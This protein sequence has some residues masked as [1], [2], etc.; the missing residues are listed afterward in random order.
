MISAAQCRAAR[1]LIEWSRA[2]LSEASG[3]DVDV[4]RD[5]EY[6][7]RQ[8]GDPVRQQLQEAL[9]QAGAVFLAENGAGEGVRLKFNRRAVQAIRRWE[10]EGGTAGEDD[11]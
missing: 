3:I 9:E 5:F 7:T 4:I 6:R 10:T 11:V 1:A 8:P 2:Q